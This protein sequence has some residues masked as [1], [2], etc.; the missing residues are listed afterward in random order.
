VGKNYAR[1][2]CGATQTKL[3]RT[4]VGDYLQLSKEKNFKNGLSESC[5]RVQ[6][7]LRKSNDSLL[8]PVRDRTERETH[9]TNSALAHR[10]YIMG[11]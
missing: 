11:H 10:R 2:E 9:A 5:A 3:P 4:T 6:D 1:V 7:T 8:A